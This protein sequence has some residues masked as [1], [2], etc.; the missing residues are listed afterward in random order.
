MEKKA[1]IKIAGIVLFLILVSTPYLL[2]ITQDL[3]SPACHDEATHHINAKDIVLFGF[4]S[5]QGDRLMSIIFPIDT[6]IGIISFFFMGNSLFSLRLPY[7]LLNILGNIL[8]FDIIRKKQGNIL[9]GIITLAFALYAPRF[10]IGKSAMVEALA[11]P[12]I[13][14]LVWIMVS[15][16]KGK[17]YYFW[18]G[19][20]GILICWI[21]LDNVFVPLV[22]AIFVFRDALGALRGKKTEEAKKI[23]LWYM[24]GVNIIIALWLIFYALV[25]WEKVKFLL[26]YMLLPNI[27]GAAWRPDVI[28]KPFSFFLFLRNT[29]FLNAGHP[30]FLYSTAAMM[31]LFIFITI[32]SRRER[33]H[34]LTKGIWLIF[35]LLI[36]KLAV[37]TIIASRRFSTCYPLPFLL[38]AEVAG[39]SLNRKKAICIKNCLIIT[40]LLTVVKISFY[41][42]NFTL[43]TTTLIKSPTYDRIHEARLLAPVF[44][45]GNKILFLD[46]C[47][48]YLAIQLQN[49][50]IDIPPD[51]SAGEHYQVESNLTLARNKIRNDKQIRYVLSRPDNPGAKEMLEKEIHAELLTASL[52]Y[53]DGALY[54]INR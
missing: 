40:L 37:S 19:A 26:T 1:A 50:F 18:T 43:I 46:G 31:I 39:F 30:G 51:L 36:M 42:S 45:K 10:I 32:S 14:L 48:G 34:P 20:L 6:L 49:K 44:K 24:A 29:Y 16:P 52:C 4:P 33:N 5:L 47:F 25:G 38:M 3:L 54:R 21:K 8:F 7:I 12:L 35:I 9:A 28:Y 17:K 22:L 23:F 15:V 2:H 41:D 11:L 53:G 13:I 27:T